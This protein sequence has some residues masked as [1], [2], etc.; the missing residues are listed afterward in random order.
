MACGEVAVMSMELF[1]I[2]VSLQGRK[3]LLVGAGEVGAAKAE[4]LLC[5]GAEIHVVALRAKGWI[6][7]QA[8]KGNLQWHA[9]AFAA[10][11]LQGMFLVIAA[12]DSAE[13]NRAVFEAARERGV[14]CNVVDDPEHCDFFYPAVVRR[15]PLQIA[16]STG[17]L[18]PA[19]AHRLRVDLEE[20]FGPEY[21]DWV[22]DVGR[23]RREILARD[24]PAED[25][26]ALLEQI[27]GREA[28]ERFVR[29]RKTKATS[30]AQEDQR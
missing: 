28:F 21:E 13:V 26:R 22:T 18:S 7:E 9:R 14:L 8:S 29:G 6:Q 19:L 1:P 2:S 11:D 17:G 27:A 12:T 15:G 5:S 23:R 10:A 24:L 16:I 20:Q 3:V 4:G 25:R 30:K